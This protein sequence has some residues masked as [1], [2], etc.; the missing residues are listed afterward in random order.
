MM[1]Q[2]P[3]GGNGGAN[4]VILLATIAGLWLLFIW[5]KMLIKSKGISLMNKMVKILIVIVLVIAVGVVIAVK[6][7]EK[8]MNSKPVAV[9]EP[10]PAAT[11]SEPEKIANDSNGPLVMTIEVVESTSASSA[12]LKKLPR[13]VDLGA[14]KCIPCK[15]M[16]PILEE[17]SAEYKD[18]L[19]VDFIDVWKNP[20]EG[21]K[22]K[23]RVIP[24]QIFFDADGKELF[25]HEGYYSKKDI[26]AKWK[27]FGL[28]FKK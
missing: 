19:Q 28:D 3:C 15:M 12:E 24:T 6:Q 5:I 16:K 18:K 23:I 4:P 14:D 8:D 13:L 27:K 10:K 9:T 17:L 2:C 1:P 21:P 22:Y 20:Q 11:Q 26:L 7:K 25:R